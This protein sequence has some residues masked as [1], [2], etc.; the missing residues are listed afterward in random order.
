MTEKSRSALNEQINMHQE[1]IR[2]A[3]KRAEYQLIKYKL[4]E[5]QFLSDNLK[6]DSIT[7]K[8]K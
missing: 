3:I 6:E 8:F 2:E 1:C 7:Q 4:I 5:I